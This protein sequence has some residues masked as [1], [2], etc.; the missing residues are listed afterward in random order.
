MIFKKITTFL[1]LLV[2][3]FSGIL[4]ITLA[5]EGDEEAGSFDND[6]ATSNEEVTEESEETSS[7]SGLGTGVWV[8]ITGAVFSTIQWRFI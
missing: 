7:G 2:F 4:P 8:A 5:S 1:T 6:D 3:T